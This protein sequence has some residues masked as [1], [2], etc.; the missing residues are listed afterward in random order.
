MDTQKKTV[1]ATER[2]E[3]ARQLWIE[4]VSGLDIRDLVFVDEFGSNTGMARAYARAPRGWWAY[5]SLPRNRG[6]NTTVIAS[7][8][9]EGIGVCMQLTGATDT[10]A[11]EAIVDRY[12]S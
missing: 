11:F 1:R 2:D 3:A 4:Q 8:T 7:L 6:P 10:A 12:P 9:V 5:D